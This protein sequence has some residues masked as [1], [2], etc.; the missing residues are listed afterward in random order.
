[1]T[2]VRNLRP[3]TVGPYAPQLIRLVREPSTLVCA[4][5]RRIQVREARERLGERG[6]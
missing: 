5:P 4:R 1:M 3:I 6:A 2:R